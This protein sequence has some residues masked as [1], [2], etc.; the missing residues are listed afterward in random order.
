MPR[1]MDLFFFIGSVYSYFAVMRAEAAASHAGIGL[2][3]RPFNLRA[4]MV[5]QDNVPRRNPVKPQYTWRDV[6]RRAARH[7]LPWP[8]RP[9][10]PVD[11]DL[12]ANRVAA[13]AAGAGW[14]A[15]YAQAIYRDWFQRHLAPGD[16]QHLAAVLRTLNQDPEAVLARANARDTHAR[17]AAETD[18]AR[19][20]G[21]FGAPTIVWNGELFWGDDRLEDALAWAAAHPDG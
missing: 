14:C 11:A 17:F 21:I 7:G 2:R 1:Q 8:G 19:R 5:E 6:E 3:W 4:I 10:Y 16:P 13:V 20:L 9:P 18:D 15:P 12:L